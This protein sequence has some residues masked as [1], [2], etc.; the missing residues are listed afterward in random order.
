[1]H[2]FADA[3]GAHRAAG[4]PVTGR[5]WRDARFE[6]EALAGVVFDRCR[7]ERVTLARC[8]L[9]GAI[10]SE[11]AF[12]ALRLEGCTLDATHWVRTRGDRLTLTGEGPPLQQTSFVECAI[13]QLEVRAPGERLVIAEGRYGTVTFAGA[14]VRQEAPT[15]SKADIARVDARG[16]RWRYA[17][18]LGADLARWALEEA[19]LERCALI[20][21]QADGVDWSQTVL[22]RCN[23]HRA[24]IERATLR[25]APG[26]IFSSV[27]MRDIDARGAALEGAMIESSQLERVDLEGAGLERSVIAHSRVAECRL[28]RA[29]AEGCAWTQ[30]AF[31]EC[32]LRDVEAPNASLRG[33]RLEDTATQGA[34]LRGCDLHG[35]DGALAGARREG[36]Q[37]TIAWRA[38]RERGFD[39]VPEHAD[40]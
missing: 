26:S 13:E 31:I 8:D 10:F 36:A 14:G 15:L 25:S 4:I 23:L 37:G 6:G 2:E 18:A 3:Q 40:A 17:S 21:A 22:R 7:L 27:T 32:D 35:V 1:M 20:D 33:S 5:T 29:R 24:H 28:G 11:C 30:S 34:N 12:E 9:S 38:E 39:A 16:A 19:E